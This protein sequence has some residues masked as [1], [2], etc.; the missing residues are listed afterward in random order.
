MLA[1]MSYSRVSQSSAISLRLQSIDR[2]ILDFILH[3]FPMR[4]ISNLVPSLT[5]VFG[6]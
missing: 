4:K 2:Y 1:R 5:Q 6:S 3:M